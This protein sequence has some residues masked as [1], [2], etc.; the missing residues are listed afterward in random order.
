MVCFNYFKRKIVL[1]SSILL[2]AF[3]IVFALASDCTGRYTELFCYKKICDS[4][5]LLLCYLHCAAFSA[6]C[7]TIVMSSVDYFRL[8]IGYVFID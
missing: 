1:V 6:P 2:I 8:N 5:E 4:A 3:G 7:P